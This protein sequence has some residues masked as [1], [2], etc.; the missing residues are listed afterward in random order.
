MGK[1][2]RHSWRRVT[3]APSRFAHGQGAETTAQPFPVITGNGSPVGKEPRRISTRKRRLQGLKPTTKP[4]YPHGLKPSGLWRASPVTSAPGD[5]TVEQ[6]IARTDLLIEKP[7]AKGGNENQ[8]NE[9]ARDCLHCRDHRQR[10]A[11]A[12]LRGEEAAPMKR[13]QAEDEGF[14]PL[15]WLRTR[16]ELVRHRPIDTSEQR[17]IMMA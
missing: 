16:R 2:L 15:Q 1:E 3:P 7:V 12:D 13:A 14:I 11:Q 8:F 10:I 4:A 6:R 9:Q 17:L 5:V